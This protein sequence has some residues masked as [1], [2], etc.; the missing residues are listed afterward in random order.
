MFL[1]ASIGIVGKIL[2]LY[3]DIDYEFDPLVLILI[4]FSFGIN[5]YN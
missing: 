4:L 5:V 3:C 1:A 2:K